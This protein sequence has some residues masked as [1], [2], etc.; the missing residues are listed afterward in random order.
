MEFSIVAEFGIIEE[1]C[2]AANRPAA[3]FPVIEIS[4]NL[5]FNSGLFQ[6]HDDFR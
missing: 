6:I 2:K 4:V 1:T 5:Q 3:C